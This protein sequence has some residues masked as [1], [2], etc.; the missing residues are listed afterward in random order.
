MEVNMASKKETEIQEQLYNIYRGILFNTP[1]WAAGG[2]I[3]ITYEFDCPEYGELLSKYPVEEVAGKGGDFERALRL[4]RWLHPRLKHKS[5]YDNHVPCNSLSLLDYC[6]EKEDAGI[7]CLNKAKILAECCLAL[8]IFA[9]RAYM[10]PFS[11]Y[12]MDNHVITEIYDR[13]R[14]AWIMLDPSMGTYLADEERKPLSLV[15]AREMTAGGKKVTAVAAR[16]SLRDIA[17]LF[18]R[19][20][21][22]GYNPYYAKNMAYFVVDIKNTFGD[23]KS[24]AYLVPEGFNLKE[25]NLQNCRY[26]IETLK[27][28]GNSEFAALMEEWYKEELAREYLFISEKALLAP[29]EN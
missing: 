18:K 11:P 28:L 13:K 29:P 2:D 24:C 3:E 25:K 9:R 21:A 4:C 6:F 12:D 7:N 16:Q 1:K 19:N 22:E 26:R 8:G 20:I 23:Q 27:E 15:A 5:D 14:R 10:Y 17:K